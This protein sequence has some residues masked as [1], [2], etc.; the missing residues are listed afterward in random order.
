MDR[1][2]EMQ[3]HEDQEAFVKQFDGLGQG[4]VALV[5]LR[6]GGKLDG[7]D[8]GPCAL[9]AVVLSEAAPDNLEIAF[10]YTD[11]SID[12]GWVVTDLEELHYQARAWLR[13]IVCEEQ[14]AQQESE[15]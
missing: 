10:R 13:A 6:P 3:A 14:I 8:Y 12:L 7:L 9:E 15:A 5:I 2:L 1:K 11:D 4:A